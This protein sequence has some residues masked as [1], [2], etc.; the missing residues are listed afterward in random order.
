MALILSQRG[1]KT[2]FLWLGNYKTLFI[3]KGYSLTDTFQLSKDSKQLQNMDDL[4]TLHPTQIV[5]YATDYCPDCI[6]AKKFFEA[7]Q[8]P[9]LRVRLE[10]NQE[11]T[12]FVMQINNGY[13]SVPTI[14]FPDGSVLVEPTWDELSKKVIKDDQV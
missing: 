13:R 11:A 3:S 1:I 2:F 7:H 5:V 10:G 9:H 8:I 14:V 6:R 12:E 4:Y